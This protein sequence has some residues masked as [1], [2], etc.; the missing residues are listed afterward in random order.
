M[1]EARLSPLLPAPGACRIDRAT[2]LPGP[3]MGLPLF[4]PNSPAG[5]ARQAAFLALERADFFRVL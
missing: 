1:A 5:L 2:A 4:V 3:A